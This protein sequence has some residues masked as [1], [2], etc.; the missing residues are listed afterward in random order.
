MWWRVQADSQTGDALQRLVGS[1]GFRFAALTFVALGSV[2]AV[3]LTAP[4]DNP[5]LGQL[6]EVTVT[7]EVLFGKLDMQV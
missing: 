2:W 5:E 4:P 6:L 3:Q 7:P 1:S